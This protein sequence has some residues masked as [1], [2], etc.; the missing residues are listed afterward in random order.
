VN[1]GIVGGQQVGVCWCAPKNLEWIR[2]AEGLRHRETCEALRAVNRMR[3]IIGQLLIKHD[4]LKVY[5]GGAKGA[6]AMA[7]TICHELGV[8]CEEIKPASGPEPF[9]FRAKVRNQKI[10]DHSEMLIAIFAP[11]PRSP[12][13][14]DTVQRALQKGIPVHVYDNGRWLDR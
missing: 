7:A 3:A 4:E 8:V 1:V 5:S 14:S 2:S 11:G 13:T 10:V 9:W 12:G 6:D